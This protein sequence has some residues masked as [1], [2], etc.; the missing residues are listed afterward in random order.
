[1][2]IC[3]EFFYPSQNREHILQRVARE[4]RG[5]HCALL[6]V[7]MMREVLWQFGMVRGIIPS[8]N[9]PFL[10]EELIRIASTQRVMIDPDLQSQALCDIASDLDPELFFAIDSQFSYLRFRDQP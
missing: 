6:I 9:R 8:E 10:T 1:M 3:Q 2:W 5:E 7:E 4:F